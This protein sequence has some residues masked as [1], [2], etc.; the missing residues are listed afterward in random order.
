MKICRGD[1][2]RLQS[3]RNNHRNVGATCGRPCSEE[4][5]QEKEK[6]YVNIN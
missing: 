2:N 6:K 5:T 3:K 1:L 4:N